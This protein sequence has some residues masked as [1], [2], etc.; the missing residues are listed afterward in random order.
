MR[1]YLYKNVNNELLCSSSGGAFK[2]IV[3]CIM[4]DGNAVIYGATWDENLMVSH[5]YVDN[6]DDLYQ[7]SGSKYARSKLG[8]TFSTVNN[9]LLNGKQVIFSGTPCQ[10]AGLSSFLKAKKTDTTNLYLIDIICHGTPSPLMLKEWIRST[11]RHYRHKIKKVSFRD[12]KVGWIGYPT[13]IV[14]DNNKT[15]RHSY[16]N[17]EFVRLFFLHTVLAPCCY[18]C[19]FANIKRI[20]D[21]TI[22]DFWG[23]EKSFPQIDYKNG[24]SLILANTSKGEEAIKA[25]ETNVRDDEI[26]RECSKASYISYQQNLNEPTNKPLIREKFWD[27]Y[28]E[29]GYDYA[30]KKYGVSDIESNFK[31]NIKM[32]LS[33]IKLYNKIF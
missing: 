7:L 5:I 28:S 32:F 22:G 9:Q 13:T 30:I 23:A 29:R 4:N 24:V 2:R 26:I 6:L 10:I 12:K 8:D 1:S 25:I 33:K 19:Q 3:S 31:H 14:L 21:I 27:A 16:K 20:S 15:I 17:Q 11:E 18:E